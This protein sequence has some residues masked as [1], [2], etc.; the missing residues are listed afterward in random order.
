MRWRVIATGHVGV[1]VALA[2]MLACSSF[3]AEETRETLPDAASPEAAAT[4]SALPA[5]G[6]C[7]PNSAFLEPQ[8]IASGP[9]SIES[10]RPLNAARTDILSATCPNDVLNQCELHRSPLS[11]V[12]TGGGKLDKISAKQ[13]EDAF[14]TFHASS[15]ALFFARGVIDGG[16]GN[17]RRLMASTL[18]GTTALPVSIAAGTSNTDAEPYVAG[19]LLFLRRE[20]GTESRIWSLEIGPDGKLGTAKLVPMKTQGKLFTPVVS[21]DQLEIFFALSTADIG[22]RS[23][24]RATPDDEFIETTETVF[25]TLPTDRTYPVW[26]SDDRCTLWLVTKTTPHGVLREAKRPAR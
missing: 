14:P 26:I 13:S 11:D 20:V 16:P 10:A 4:D 22:L 5:D 24:R 12:G 17:Q 1:G 2:T 19:D 3:G 18:N 6:G 21:K 23:A 25:P 9:E 15:N 7:D 8:Q